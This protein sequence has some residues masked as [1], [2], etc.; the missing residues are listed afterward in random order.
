MYRMRTERIS[1]MKSFLRDEL[2]REEGAEEGE[3]K[4]TLH[5]V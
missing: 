5:S 3:R 1:Q 2:K 4:G